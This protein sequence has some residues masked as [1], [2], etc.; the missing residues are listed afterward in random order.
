MKKIQK[1]FDLKFSVTKK[2]WYKDT[3]SENSES[4]VLCKWKNSEKFLSSNLALPKKVGAQ[5]LPLKNSDSRALYKWK[6]S[7]IFFG[8]KFGMTKKSCFRPLSEK[9][10]P[11][12]SVNEKNP[13]NFWSQ[14]QSDQKKLV[15]RTPN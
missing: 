4:R 13:K 15:P 14:I 7:K 9:F 1:I 6:H 2:C 12:H 11:E 8:L 10:S 5:T 3:P